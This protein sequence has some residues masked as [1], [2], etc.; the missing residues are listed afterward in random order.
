MYEDNEGAVHVANNLLGS[1]RAK[2]NDVQ[3]HF[4]RDMAREGKICVRQVSSLK[5][6]M[7]I[8]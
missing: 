2:H 8:Y 1:A 7:P 4:L 5:A 3:Y 6:N